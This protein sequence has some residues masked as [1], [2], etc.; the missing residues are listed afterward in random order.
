MHLTLITPAPHTP[1]GCLTAAERRALSSVLW[2]WLSLAAGRTRAALQ[3]DPRGAI[4]DAAVT[5]IDHGTWLQDVAIL[6]PMALSAVRAA[7]M[8]AHLPESPRQLRRWLL[9]NRDCLYTNPDVD[10]CRQVL[11]LNATLEGVSGFEDDLDSLQAMSTALI[12]FHW[13]RL[14][15]LRAPVGG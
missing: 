1:A 15:V 13:D 3:G 12:R 8:L 11:R 14:E 2:G 7:A 10:T 6:P 4:I 9:I 5:S